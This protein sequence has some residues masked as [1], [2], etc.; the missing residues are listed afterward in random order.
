MW[1]TYGKENRSANFVRRSHF[2]GIQAKAPGKIVQGGKARSGRH[3]ADRHQPRRQCGR[4]AGR[5][6]DFSQCAT[7]PKQESAAFK[8]LKE[9]VSKPHV[10][11]L[12]NVLDTTNQNKKPN[13]PFG[14]QSRSRTTR[15]SVRT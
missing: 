15:P 13:L 10:Q 2:G 14:M 12:N 8:H 11:G 1:N 4:S 6:E 5:S 7:A 9:N 3:T